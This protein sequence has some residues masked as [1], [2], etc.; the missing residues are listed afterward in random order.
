MATYVK[1]ITQTSVR[2]LLSYNPETG[3]LV[4]RERRPGAA[5]GTVAGR[6]GF[7]TFL[8]SRVRTTTLI[9]WHVHGHA[10]AAPVVH[11][12]GDRTDFRLENLK[13]EEAPPAVVSA[14]SVRSLLTYDPATGRLAWR[15]GRPGASAGAV[16][17]AG[18]SMTLFG[19]S[20]RT[21]T[22]IWWH[23]HGRAPSASIYHVNSIRTDFRLS[24][25]REGAAAKSMTTTEALRSLLVYDPEK[26]SLSWK[27]GGDAVGADGLVR[28]LGRPRSRAVVT[29]WIVYGRA[30][31]GRIEHLNRDRSDFR[32]SN[33][34][35]RL[36][37]APASAASLREVL[38][39]DAKGALRWRKTGAEAGAGGVLTIKGRRY[40]TARVVAMLGAGR[41]AV[42]QQGDG[43]GFSVAG[44]RT[45]E[46]AERAL[47]V[48]KAAAIEGRAAP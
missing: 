18:G 27:T 38:D 5:A 14:E 6:W 13:E 10:P 30:P 37:P 29:W 16:A 15:R 45:R 22:V 24:N 19:R 23:V 9:W 17:G 8:G 40:A 26:G 33:L 1:G 47:A 31:K 20:I 28:A 2:D 11:V 36:P 34:R 43:W 21:T 44:F 48:A 32:L 42:T 25:L 7:A 46:A 12:N 35:E 4:W 41:P 39:L 3:R